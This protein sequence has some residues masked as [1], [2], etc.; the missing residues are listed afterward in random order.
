MNYSQTNY[1]KI[2]IIA[3]IVI[4]IAGMLVPGASLVSTAFASGKISHSGNVDQVVVQSNSISATNSGAGGSADASGNSQSNSA[5]NSADVHI[6]NGGHHDSGK[7]AYHGNHGSGGKI[8][9]SGNVDQ[10]IVQSNSISATNSGAG[11]SATADLNS[12]SNTATN[13]ANV[14]IHNHGYYGK[15]S[16]S[17]NVEQLIV[18]SNDISANNSP[19]ALDLIL[20][21]ADA[22]LNNQTN[23]A[24]NSA[25]V[26]IG[27]H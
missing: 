12:Q 11:G 20:P 13:T 18:Q 5:S 10:A 26:S 3:A 9:H 4:G 27:N 14:D 2:S 22:S 6:H 19:T 16:H 1:R 17:G 7:I 8:S 21:S 23:S 25:D 24:S 15:I